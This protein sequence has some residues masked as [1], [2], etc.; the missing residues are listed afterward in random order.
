MNVTELTQAIRDR[1]DQPETLERLYREHPKVFKTAFDQVY[2]ELPQSLILRVWAARLSFQK[3]SEP[4]R[5]LINQI[6]D[7]LVILFLCLLA[8]TI[9]KIPGFLAFEYPEA[10]SFWERNLGY[11]VAP[12]L[13]AYF[14]LRNRPG[15]RMTAATIA[16]LVLPLI[17]INTIPKLLDQPNDYWQASQTYNLACLHLILFLWTVVGMPFCGK[18][19]GEAPVRMDYLRYSGETLIFS[20]LLLISGGLLAALTYGLFW[21][22]SVD[23]NK[24]YGEYILVY[25]LCAAPIVAT[26]LTAARDRFT[27]NL[28]PLLSKIFSP[29]V[30]ITLLIYLLVIA[31]LGKNP[32][33]DRDFL[34]TFNAMLLAVV[35]VT[36]F[37]LSE[38]DKEE[39]RNA[40]D[41]VITSLIGVALIV[42]AIAL[43]AIAFRLISFGITPNR[44]A[45]LGS[46][47][48]IFLH[49]IGT[50]LQYSRFLT[51]RGN[52]VAIQAW[53]AGYL[54]VYAV[55]SAI[56][57][58]VFPSLFG[59]K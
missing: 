2:Q 53:V 1:L 11:Y 42:D 8:G 24:I 26:H 52:L 14:L 15:K 3:V 27:G 46:N 54:P 49:L 22:I 4:I 40:W 51:G 57:T 35:S 21:A 43:S 7:W 55:W 17:F 38:R 10:Q 33:Q 37:T 16:L 5:R 23:I 20:T 50:L 59:F 9:A 19:W 28:A 44:L 41:F 25:G 47:V 18:R 34:I 12:F 29:L 58:F 6:P 45:I 31:G 32:F 13:A 36:I 56:V 48:A 30:L 39:Q